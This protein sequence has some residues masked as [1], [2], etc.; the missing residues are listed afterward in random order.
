MN[1]NR[2]MAPARTESPGVIPFLAPP[3][4]AARVKR[5]GTRTT[6]EDDFGD[7]Q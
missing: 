4:S 2:I 1:E 5:R 3:P 7:F 6:N